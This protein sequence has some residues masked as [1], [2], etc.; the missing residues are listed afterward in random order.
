LGGQY[1]HCRGERRLVDPGEQ[2]PGGLAAEVAE[3]L[4]DRGQR[5]VDDPA[6]VHVVEPGDRHVG[7]DPHARLLQFA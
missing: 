2:P 6:G 1:L 4:A 5:R 3:R 7:G